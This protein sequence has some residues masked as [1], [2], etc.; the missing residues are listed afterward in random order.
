MRDF[1]ELVNEVLGRTKCAP[2]LVYFNGCANVRNNSI[3]TGPIRILIMIGARVKSL[4]FNNKIMRPSSLYFILKLYS[5]LVNKE[6]ERSEPHNIQGG[7]GFGLSPEVRSPGTA[8]CNSRP[9]KE[10]AEDS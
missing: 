6:R 9:N 1:N 5:L 7:L 8:S 4:N 3:I 2:K 10:T